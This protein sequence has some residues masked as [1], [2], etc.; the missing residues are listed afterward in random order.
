MPN[1]YEAL[2]NQQYISLTTYRKTGQ[3]MATPVWFVDAGSVIYIWTEGSSGKVKRLRNN[4]KV[5][6]A[7]SDGRGKILGPAFQATGRVF[8]LENDPASYKK[9]DD[10]MKKKYG[11][12]LAMFRFIGKLSGK[13]YVF[14]EVKPA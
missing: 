13:K 3:A 5:E 4:Q 7:A 6:L 8:N 2:R 10:A 9:A 14:I 11:F 1:L 12:G